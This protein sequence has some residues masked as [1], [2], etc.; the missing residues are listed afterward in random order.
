MDF[1]TDKSFLRLSGNMLNSYYYK[2]VLNSD[3]KIVLQ[4]LW[5]SFLNKGAD[6]YSKGI[7]IVNMKQKTLQ[8][9]AGNITRSTSIRSLQKL[10]KLGAIIKVENNAKNN[11]YLIG[12]RT[13]GGDNL[14]LIYYL[15]NK[16][17]ETI[18]N[19]VENQKRDLTEKWKGPKIKD[20]NAYRLN[21]K[22]RDFI[23]NNIEESKL[24]IEKIE[25]NK[26]LFE[27]LFN[28]SDYYRFKFSDLIVQ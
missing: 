3:D 4:T 14:Y 11:K 13:E 12:F 24:F 25:N 22:I 9:K 10:D 15:I 20:I 26:T 6:S 2:W 28:R 19:D 18:I 23:T 7:L 17:N 5:R 21:N 16:Y 1:I 27:I 8:E